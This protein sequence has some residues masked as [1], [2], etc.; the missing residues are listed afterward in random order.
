MRM[1]AD[2]RTVEAELKERGAAREEYD[3]AIA[4]GPAGRDRRG[5]AARRVHHAGRQHPARRAGHASRCTL[6]GPLPYEDGEAT[7]RFPLVVAPRYIPGAPLAGTARRRRLRAATP[8]PC[9]TRRGSRRRCCCPASPTRCGCRIGVDI[10]PAGLPL[11]EVRSSLHTVVARGR[12]TCSIQP[13]ERVEPRLHPAPGL[14]RAGRRRRRRSTLTPDADG[15]RGHVPADR[16]AAADAGAG[17]GPRD[18]VLLLDRSGSMSGWKMV[19][20][21]RAAARIVDTLTAADR[22]AVLAFDDRVE[23]PP[24]L[25]AG[26]RPGHRPAPLPRR[27]APR[28]G[29]RPRRHRAARAAAARRWTCSPTRAPRPRARAGHRRPGRQRGPDPAPAPRSR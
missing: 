6:V 29:R 11:G 26:L 27:R 10:D 12:A 18:V 22:F 19:A 14:R 20:A 5:G 17:R 15:R 2:G 23:H 16:A 28:P 8:T 13:G 4:A 1:T 9:P 24:T 7:F 25:A 21:R 3:Q